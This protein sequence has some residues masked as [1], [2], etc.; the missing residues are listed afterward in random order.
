MGKQI[1]L[2][3]ATNRFQLNQKKAVGDVSVLISM[4]SP[5]TEK[6]W[7]EYYFSH[8][9]SRKEVEDL[10]SRLFTRIQDTILP[11]IKSISEQDCKDYIKDLLIKKTFEGRKARYQILYGQLF[12]ETGKSFKF[13]PNDANEWPKNAEDWRIRTFHIDYFHYDVDADL[14]IGIKVC[15][16]SM[17]LSSDPTVVQARRGIEQTH[18]EWE[19]KEAGRF[20]I[21]YYV[22]DKDQARIINTEVLLEIRDL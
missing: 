15:P 1:H 13:L 2:N 14:L 3:A 17:A 11:E 19:Q 16:Q 7:E 21:L 9:K 6:D 8:S 4:A 5:Y 18:H 10:G 20:F 22:G 12:G